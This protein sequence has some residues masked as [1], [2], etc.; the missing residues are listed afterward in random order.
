[1][2]RA[3]PFM[4]GLFA[5]V[6][7]A[8]GVRG[9]LPGG[10]VHALAVDMTGEWDMTHTVTESALQAPG[11]KTPCKWS[12]TQTG[13]DVSGTIA[14][15][16]A[17]PIDYPMSGTVDDAGN[18]ELKGT[19]R[20]EAFQMDVELTVT[21]KATDTTITGNYL[22]SVPLGDT[23]GTVEG[24]RIG[25]PPAAPAAAPPTGGAPPASD[26][27]LIWWPLILAGALLASLGAASAV[28]GLRRAAH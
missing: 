25:A 27:G 2:R 11:T 15:G 13:S 4:I 18:F 14:C 26:G 28:I 9:G 24:T 1:M 5:L 8:L 3:W 17:F 23:K 7:L 12:L 21:G 16:G 22:A 19:G 10:T 20:R 6:A